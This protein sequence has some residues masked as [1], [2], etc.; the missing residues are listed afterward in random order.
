[1]RVFKVA[2]GTSWVAEVHDGVDVDA[3][4]AA[5][6]AGWEVILFS[7]DPAAVVQRLV[8][9]PA[10]W[11][12]QATLDELVAALEEGAAVRARWGDAG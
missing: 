11:L 3:G 1:M 6:R 9:R 5:D 4:A 7:A 12:A 8:Y 2:D 10:G